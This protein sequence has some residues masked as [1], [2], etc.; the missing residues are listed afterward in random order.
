MILS[1]TFCSRMAF[2]AASV[3]VYIH[4]LAGERAA[5]KLGPDGL[6]AGDLLP[7]IPRVLRRLRQEGLGW[8][9]FKKPK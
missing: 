5:R 6:L 7:E 2:D 3:G 9:A 4:G 1:W 8:E